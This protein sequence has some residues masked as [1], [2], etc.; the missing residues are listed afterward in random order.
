M[1]QITFE[2]LAKEALTRW[3]AQVDPARLVRAVDILQ[4]NRWNVQLAHRDE[5]DQPIKPSYAVLIVRGSHGWYVVRE[6]SCTC[7][8]SRA[9]HICKHRIAAWLYRESIIRPLAE[10]GLK[11]GAQLKKELGF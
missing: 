9:G 6:K 4:S 11:T 8:D 10:A 7:P 5:N 2:T 1:I 3:P